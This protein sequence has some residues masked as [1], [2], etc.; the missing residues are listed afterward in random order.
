MIIAHLR[1]N[2]AFIIK[3]QYNMLLSKEQFINKKTILKKINKHQNL[4][5]RI[6]LNKSKFLT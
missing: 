5:I 1:N 4:F 2:K 3:I 6:K